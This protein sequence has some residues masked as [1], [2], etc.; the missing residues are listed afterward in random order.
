M[1]CLSFTKE[2]S[3]K[4]GV[5]LIP[6]AI[7][8]F[9]VEFPDPPLLVAANK[10]TH[11]EKPEIGIVGCRIFVTRSSVAAVFTKEEGVTMTLLQVAVGVLLI[12]YGV[13]AQGSG[14][15]SGSERKN[16]HLV[17]LPTSTTATKLCSDL[18]G[19]DLRSWLQSKWTSTSMLL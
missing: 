17:L 10:N 1:I 8:S 18:R 3:G 5:C 4:T 14:S 19:A 7:A 2:T 13:R 6:R 16:N 11:L 12:A 9:F 15:G